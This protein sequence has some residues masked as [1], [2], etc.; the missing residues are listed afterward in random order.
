M[1][2]ADSKVMQESASVPGPWP[3]IWKCDY[4]NLS[5]IYVHTGTAAVAMQHT[6]FQLA[7]VSWC[8]ARLDALEAPQKSATSVAA[9]T[10]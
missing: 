1:Q 7:E 9:S 2:A 4:K 10:G 8:Y 3:G 5:M 6:D